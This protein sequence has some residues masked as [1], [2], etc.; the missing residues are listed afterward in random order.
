ML[1]PC[2]VVRR[3]PGFKA[4]HDAVGLERRRIDR[5]ALADRALE[6]LEDVAV[7]LH[8]P[9]WTEPDQQSLGARMRDEIAQRRRR[10]FHESRLAG[11]GIKVKSEK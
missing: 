11:P 10:L 9:F 2:V 4:G 3:Q 1:K 7:S 5:M 6:F 8:D